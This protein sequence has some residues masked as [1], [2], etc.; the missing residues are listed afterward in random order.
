MRGRRVAVFLDQK[1]K[2]QVGLDRADAVVEKVHQLLSPDADDSV[3]IDR[4]L[5]GATRLPSV[6]VQLI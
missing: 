3:D 2:E 4:H 6:N 1:N 5:R